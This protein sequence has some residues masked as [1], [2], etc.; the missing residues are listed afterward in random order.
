MVKLYKEQFGRGP[1][2]VTTHYRGPD[3]IV[4]ILGNSLTPVEPTLRDMG[5]QQR[6]RDIR[7]SSSTPP[8]RSSAPWSSRQ[9][10]DA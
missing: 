7:L 1:E 10:G 3:A 9:P 4:S 6:L 5:E 2:V 8:S